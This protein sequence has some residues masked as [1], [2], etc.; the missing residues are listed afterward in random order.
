MTEKDGQQL[1]VMTNKEWRMYLRMFDLG[2]GCSVPAQL[3]LPACLKSS[4]EC[5]YLLEPGHSK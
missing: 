3:C 1:L 2:T 4:W 5:G